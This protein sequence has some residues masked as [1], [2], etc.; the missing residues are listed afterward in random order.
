MIPG[1]TEGLQLM[2]EGGKYELYIPL[3]LAY[4]KRGPLAFQ[5]LIFEIELLEVEPA[6]GGAASEPTNS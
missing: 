1:W 4:G 5:T 3:D 2:K 6:D